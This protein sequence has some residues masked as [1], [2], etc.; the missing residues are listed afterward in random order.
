[1]KEKEL[2]SKKWNDLLFEYRNKDYGAYRLRAETGRRYACAL[3]VLLILVAL[4]FCA[5]SSDDVPG[6]A[7]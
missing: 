7:S 6:E 2:Y 3:T 1:M 5:P 4:A